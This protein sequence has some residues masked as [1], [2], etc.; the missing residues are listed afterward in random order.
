M[1][2]RQFLCQLDDIADGGSIGLWPNSRGR[3]LVLAVRNDDRV[4]AYVNLCPHYEKSRLGWKKNEFLNGDGSMILCAAHGALFRI[5][6]GLCVLG[7][8]QGKALAEV[9]VV[10][11]N[12]EVF[13]QRSDLPNRENRTESAQ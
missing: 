6:D 7:P 13:A 8:C 4:Q 2:A 10:V 1:T 11:K 5:D 3:D 9:R 12:G